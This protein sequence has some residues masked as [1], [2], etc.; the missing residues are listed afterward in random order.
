MLCSV[1]HHT[2]SNTYICLQAN[3]ELEEARAEKRRLLSDQESVQQRLEALQIKYD[4]ESK[5]NKKHEVTIAKLQVQLK[6]KGPR[7]KVRQLAT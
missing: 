1:C 5:E 6:D 7:R 3:K 4:E 2:L